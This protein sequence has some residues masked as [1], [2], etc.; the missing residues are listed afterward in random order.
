MRT[1]IGLAS[2]LSVALLGTKS[3][4]G[5]SAFQA[6]LPDVI[7]QT[8]AGAMSGAPAGCLALEWK[9]KATAV[10]RFAREAEPGLQAYLA[11]ATTGTDLGPVYKRKFT[12]P[13]SIDG[14]ATQ[15]L[16]EIRDPWAA[17]VARLETVG[18]M[19]GR[20][21]VYGRGIWRAYDG[22]GALLGTYDVEMVRKTKGY[23]IGRLK[24]WSP[25]REDQIAPLTPY[26]D[27][28]GDHEAYVSAVA[29]IKA[30][31]AARKAEKLAHRRVEQK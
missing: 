1:V 11:L 7:G 3:T 25:G 5:Q 14:A 31:K 22:D 13:W 16:L 4:Y 12:D 2:I 15:N 9:E 27:T 29:E 8:V 18:L 6:A 21:Q 10:A 17:K 28:P 26:C 24:L 30:E 20:S 19:L 23:A